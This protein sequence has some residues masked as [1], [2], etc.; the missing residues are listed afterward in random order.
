MG[1]D[2]SPGVTEQNN[3]QKRPFNRVLAAP[4]QLLISIALKSVKMNP[5]HKHKHT[6]EM[7]CVSNEDNAKPP[8]LLGPKYQ[9]CGIGIQHG[10][11]GSENVSIGSS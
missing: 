6:L 3:K 1:S 10:L 9:T 5:G 4:R 7:F 11:Q 2:T 8:R